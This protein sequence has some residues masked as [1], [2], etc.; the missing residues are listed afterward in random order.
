MARRRKSTGNRDEEST[1]ERPPRR[2][3]RLLLKLGLVLAATAG[4]VAVAPTIIAN[5]PLREML[6][7]WQVPTPGWQI[8]C[9]QASLSWFGGQSL[10]NVAI[11]SPEGK[12]LLTVE[13]LS[14]ERSLLGLAWQSQNIGQVKIVRPTAYVNTRGEGSNVEDFLAGLRAEPPLPGAGTA[15]AEPRELPTVALE[16]VEGT[17]RVFDE[18]TQLQWAIEQ[19]NLAASVGPTI[20]AEGTALVSYAP[21]DDGGRIKIRLQPNPAG[22]Q[23]LDLLAEGLLLEPLRPWLARYVGDCQLAGSTECE[24][25][26]TWNKV[27]NGQLAISTWGHSTTKGLLLAGEFLR[28]DQLACEQLNLP[29]KLRVAGG[30]AVIEELKVDAGWAKLLASGTVNFAEPKALPARQLPKRELSLRGNVSLA[31]LAA[32]LPHTL[33]LREGVRIDSGEVQFHAQAAKGEKNLEWIAEASITDLAGEERGRA[34]RWDQPVRANARWVAT[35]DGPRLD[36]FSLQAPF[37]QADFTTSA[38][39]IAGDIECDLGLLTQEVGQFVDLHD[40]A[41]Q[42][43]ASGK[44]EINN[45]SA[46][47]FT[48]V[49][50]LALSALLLSQRE[51]PLWEENQLTIKLQAD[52]TAEHKVPRTLANGSLHLQGSR[53]TLHVE[54]VEPAPLNGT[55]P[56]KFSA[57]STGSLDAWA[58][59]LRPWL[60]EGKL[61]ISGDAAL[62]ARCAVN[63]GGIEVGELSGKIKQL[64]LWTESLAIDEPQVEFS[65]DLSYNGPSRSISS[66]NLETRGSILAFKSRD[67]RFEMPEGQMPVVTGQVAFQTD[68]KRLVS[69][70]RFVQSS[71]TLT[72]QGVAQGRLRFA[73][74]AQQLLAEISLD[75]EQ[76]QLIDSPRVG[77]TSRVEPKTLW[78]EPRLHAEGKAVY[79]NASDKLVLE[80][81]RIDGQTLQ[82]SG[83]AD[84]DHPRSGGP[85]GVKGTLQY[86]PAAL[87]Q[88]IANYAGPEVNVQGDR[89]VRFQALGS[90]PTAGSNAGHWSQSWQA[91]ADAGWTGANVFGLPVSAGKLQGTLARG[92]IDFAPLELSVGEGKFSLTPRATLDPA[93]Q[94][95]LLPSGP[96]LTGVQISPEVSEKMLKYIAPFLA[97]A[98]RVDGKF[99]IDLAETQIPLDTPSRA[100]TAGKLS[101]HQLTV[102]PGPLIADLVGTIQQLKQLKDGK[103][104]LQSA[105][106]PKQSKLLS[107]QDQQIEFQVVDGRVYH[108]NLEFVID[109]VPVRSQGSVGFDQSLAVVLEIPIQ[110][111]WIEKEES[112]SGL[113]GQTIQVPIY[114]TFDK[115]QIDNRAVADATRQMIRSTAREAL[116]NEVNRQL[117]KLFKPR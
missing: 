44:L 32:M 43:T 70:T 115:P 81:L 9:E 87:A 47:E 5:S 66:S 56:W 3:R 7:N 30:Q 29:W 8:R 60:G 69:S 25:H 33:S 39:R 114:G 16:I 65:G 34:I 50:D 42:G 24:G 37:A 106:A 80:N 76:L 116:G 17:L 49:A 109:K 107:M 94:Q 52:G 72:P 63:P 10:T 79:T 75:A 96:L 105:I 11:V 45:Q 82:L 71:T 14:A 113:A 4:A 62:A 78:T 83:Q 61:D 13:S 117:E 51:Q 86:E 93:P 26:V 22:E 55:G 111:R 12:P 36:Q 85:I 95:V 67:L 35:A 46:G 98:T 88:L 92:R 110:D 77:G 91:T 19:A 48:A 54:L 18:V 38:N 6:L 68:L 90:L 84:W 15:T 41:L 74:N 64:H 27:A 1:F 59:R 108:R 31:R 97:G 100:R 89:V 73:T 40:F 53:D 23:Q 21:G 104:L 20:S 57:Q 102:L 99:S 103:D 58:G 112:L 101:V 2:K 28:G